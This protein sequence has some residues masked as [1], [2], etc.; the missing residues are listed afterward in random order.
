MCTTELH[1]DYCFISWGTHPEFTF[2]N[3]ETV[4]LIIRQ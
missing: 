4:D 3:S 2:A 1:G